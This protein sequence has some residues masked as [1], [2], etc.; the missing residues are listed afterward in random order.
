MKRFRLAGAVGAMA[1]FLAAHAFAEDALPGDIGG[2]F[3]L[4]DQFGATRTE[5]D[6]QQRAQ[7]LF[8]GYVN[9]QEI[10]SAA[11]PLMADV[12]DL[13][14]ERGL[15]VTP[16]L[17]TVDPA[18]DRVDTMGAPL[19]E[20]HSDFV[21]LTGTEDAL[22]VAYDAFSVSFE[23]LFTD[24]EY[25]PVFSHGSF[26]YLLDAE[27]EVLTLLPPVLPPDHMAMIVEANLAGAS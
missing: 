14:S 23:E 25:G 8:F 12:A 16:V 10:C 9:C 2:P 15:P 26:I 27:G 19:A 13:M 18:R 20:L 22:Q 3:A 1:L 6:P 4:T 5:A 24:P 7:L 11:L 21:G 17:V